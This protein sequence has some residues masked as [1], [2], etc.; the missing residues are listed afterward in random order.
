[1]ALFPA[2]LVSTLAVFAAIRSAAA[3]AADL[4]PAVA[5]D[6]DAAVAEPI[7]AAP[8]RIDAVGRVLA[9]VTINGRGPF[10][11]IVDTGANRSALSA[12]LVAKLGLVALP[13]D[14][15]QLTGVTG[16]ARVPAVRIALLEAG[17]LKLRDRSFPIVETQVLADADG[18]L[19]IEG[20]QDKRLDIDFKHNRVTISR[21]RSTP[22][23]FGYYTVPLRK[24]SGLILA[25]AQVGSVTARAVIDTGAE[26]SLGNNE[27]RRRLERRK[28]TTQRGRAGPGTTVYGATADVQQGESLL[29]P[30]I[31]IGQAEL[32]NLEVTFGD[33]Y[34]FRAWQMES[35]PAV[36][37]GMDLLG[38]A[39][40]LIIDYR[41]SELQI[42]APRK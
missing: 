33:L 36:L 38:T 4:P 28:L 40:H 41:R 13:G 9:A 30:P 22:A 39:E 10:R 14:G 16:T 12:A 19:G 27:L 15:I 5:G 7:Y 2:L 31:T 24:R 18:I 6:P 20:L 37:L 35:M 25:V 32:N 23:P 1:M 11:F 8:T 26:R 29:A 3:H 42:K 34:L 17:D 21:S